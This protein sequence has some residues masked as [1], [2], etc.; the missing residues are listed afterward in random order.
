MSFNEIAVFRTALGAISREHPKLIN[1]GKRSL[2]WV[3][4]SYPDGCFIG[5]QELADQAGLDPGTVLKYLRELTKL[6]FISREQTYARKGVRQCYRVN[7]RNVEHFLSLSPVTPT[8]KE[9]IPLLPIT[10]ESKPVTESVTAYHPEYP[11]KD[12]KDYKYDKD[13]DRLSTETKTALKIKAERWHV[14]SQGLDDYVKRK[15][16]HSVESEKLLD[17]IESLPRWSLQRLQDDL[18]ALEFGNSYDNCGLLMRHLRDLAG[19]V[20]APK[21]VPKETPTIANEIVNA[22]SDVFAMPKDL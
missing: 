2:L 9:P 8:D 22:L 13:K 15:W 10:S 3:I 14:I 6:G 5:L 19:V 21:I 20:S 12:Y 4:V 7:L 18:S 1:A 17:V 11:Y 16:S